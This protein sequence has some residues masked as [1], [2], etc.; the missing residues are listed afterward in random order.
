MVDSE[1]ENAFEEI[2]ILFERGDFDSAETKLQACIDRWRVDTE[3]FMRLF[4]E[5]TTSRE[6]RSRLTHMYFLNYV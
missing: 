6:I 2:K 5:E 4:A 3:R 1:L